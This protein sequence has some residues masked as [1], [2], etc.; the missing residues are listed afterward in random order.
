MGTREEITMEKCG[1]SRY[2]DL[3]MDCIWDVC[4]LTCVTHF[5]TLLG[6]END[7]MKDISQKHLK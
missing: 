7:C 4:V 2:W 6:W 5:G 3:L 1:E